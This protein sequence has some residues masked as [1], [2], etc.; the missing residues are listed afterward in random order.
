M[1]TV[2]QEV[3]NL[4]VFSNL[5]KIVYYIK[6]SLHAKITHEQKKRKRKIEQKKKIIQKEKVNLK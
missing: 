5:K 3:Q 6:F 4:Y 2:K 1:S